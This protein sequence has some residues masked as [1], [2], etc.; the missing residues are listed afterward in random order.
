LKKLMLAVAAL[1]VAVL[2]FGGLRAST[3]YAN[4]AKIWV[5]N[6]NVSSAIATTP[7]TASLFI[8]A[9]ETSDVTR[10]PYLTQLDAFETASAGQVAQTAATAAFAGQTLVVVQTDGSGTNVTLNGRGLVCGSATATVSTTDGLSPTVAGLFTTTA[11]HNLAVGDKITISGITSTPT[12]NG[13][14]YVATVPTTTTF[15]VVGLPTITTAGS[16]AGTITPSGGCDAVATQAPNAT[17]HI[18]VY[19]VVSAGAHAV[20]DTLVVTANQD[21]ITLDSK[22]LT[23]VGQAHDLALVTTKTTI[24]E[25]LT[26]CATTDSTSNPARAGAGAIYTDINGNALV[27][28]F[29]SWASSAAANMIVA[30]ATT[31]SELLSDGTT[32]A[33]G[34][35][36]CGVAAGT[37]NLTAKNAVAAAITGIAGQVTRTQAITIS[38]VPDAIALTASPAQIA[39]DGSATSTV[40]AKVT[41]SAGND[42]VDNTPVTFSVVALGTANPISVKTT[43]GSASS[44]ITPLSGSSAGVI[45]I[46]SSGSVQA[47]IRVDCSLAVA[48]PAAAA[49][50]ATPP[51]GVIVPPST[52]NG[53]YMGQNGSTGLP[54]WTLIALALG[55]VALVGGSVVTRRSSK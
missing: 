39:C 4:P 52:G 10:A 43:A 49:P 25:G 34:N 22:S 30:T 1:T 12:I 5:I 15:T 42:V 29:T 40:T 38:G 6:A 21:A 8:T 55:S 53:G 36:I 14:W 32:I 51:G 35:V 27:G 24:Q 28:Y 50:T 44:T 19:N 46:V 26:A 17:D 23:V 2:G 31:P 9:M 18:A 13:V 16:T 37:A 48:T 11:A 54:M 7:T 3:T 33:A 41:D 45:V 20:S 47:S